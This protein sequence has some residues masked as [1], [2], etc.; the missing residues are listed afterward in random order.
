M[1]ETQ[2]PLVHVATFDYRSNRDV[3]ALTLLFKDYLLEGLDR[4]G[5]FPSGIPIAA[6]LNT[7]VLYADGQPAGFCSADHTRYAIE[8]IYIAPEYR[9]LGIA[10]QILSDLRDSCP[11]Q[12][13]IKAPL[14][15]ACQALVQRLGIPIS[16]PSAAERAEGEHAI[17]DLHNNIRQ[18]CQHRRVGTPHRPCHRCY[19]ALLR[20]MAV[21]MVT[22]PCVNLR[23]AARLLDGRS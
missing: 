1:T 17:T 11:E 8:L 4:L 23:N 10:R 19:Q 3:E 15:P 7:T 12:M 16:E 14:S 21:A 5:H 2:V 22:E 20:R 18:H 6:W 13:H 9:R